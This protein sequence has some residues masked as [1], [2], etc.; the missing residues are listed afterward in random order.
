MKEFIQAVNGEIVVDN[1]VLKKSAQST[2]TLKSVKKGEDP[3][4]EAASEPDHGPVLP[5]HVSNG[6]DIA[7]GPGRRE[8]RLHQPGADPLPVQVV[9]QFPDF[10]LGIEAFEESEVLAG[11]IVESAPVHDIFD[12]PQHPYTIGLLGSIP[13]QLFPSPCRDSCVWPVAHP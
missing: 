10:M 4:A 6:A 7:G 2:Q 1:L 5:E 11:K 3:K 8:Q 13:R 12:S 9:S